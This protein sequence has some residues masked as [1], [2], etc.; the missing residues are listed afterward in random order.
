MYYRL[1]V[2]PI[3]LPPIRERKGDLPIL[4]KYFFRIKSIKLNKP[5]PHIKEDIYHNMLQYNWPGNIRELENFIE[6]IVNLRGDS[7]F[8]LEEDFKNIEDKHNFHEN[9]IGLLYN[10][11]IRTLEEIE[12]EAIINTVNEYNRN[13]SQSAK[14]LGITRATL[15]SKLK[16]YN[17]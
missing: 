17:I 9:N 3:K 5:M 8:I 10:N 15:Y 1:S 12:K 14:A 7:S 4:I 13:M 16:K 11:K 2:I 6:N